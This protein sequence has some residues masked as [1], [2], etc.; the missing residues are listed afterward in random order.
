MSPEEFREAGRRLVDRIADFLATQ[1]SLPV[2]P[3]RTPAEIRERLGRGG[4]PRGG[5]PVE[6]LLAEA[7]DLLFEN[8]VLPGHPR[9]LAYV[10]GAPAPLGA[11]ADLL[12]AAVN[13]NLGAWHLAPMASEI[14]AQ[15]VRWIAELIGFPPA[16]GGLLTSGGNV[17]NFVGFLAARAAKAP[18]PIRSAGTSPPGAPPLRV[19]ASEETHTW[20]H[21]AADLFGLGTDAIRWVPTDPTQRMD[22]S[23]LERLVAEDR[24]AAR[25]PF[26]VVGSAGTVSTGAVD[27]LPRLAALC[28]REGLWFHVDGAYGGFAAGVEG[29]PEELDGIALADSVAVDPHKWM[30]VPLEAG[31]T[32]VRETARLRAAF[33]H[34]PP[35]YPP[36]DGT[37]ETFDYHGLGLQNSRG[38]R[39]LKV[40][41]ELRRCGRDG[42]R[43]MIARDIALARRLFDAAGRHPELEPVTVGLSITTFRY[44]PPDLVGKE[45]RRDEEYLDKLNTQL[46]DRLQQEGE[47]YPSH[48]VVRGRSVIRTCIVNFR[49]SEEDVDAV[50]EIVARAGRDL[51]RSLRPGR[52]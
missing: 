7:S 25:F 35:Y 30:Y 18:W 16:G 5:E 52:G 40:W 50:P 21:K 34:R 47:V 8:S 23:A 46:V 37:E 32:L 42:Y 45:G 44:V 14:E 28:R 12:A 6:R 43:S 51:D 26:L 15:S 29:A 9:F 4:L 41:L 3:G 17:A 19:Y 36:A 10:V 20:I 31:C 22:V 13:Q 11:L 39:A 49:T 2:G 38:F 1:R 48:A 24:A 33:E 27:D